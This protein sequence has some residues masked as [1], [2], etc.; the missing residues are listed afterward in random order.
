[1]GVTRNKHEEGRK[2]LGPAT[3]PRAGG[4]GCR[5]DTGRGRRDPG[6]GGAKGTVAR[7]WDRGEKTGWDPVDEEHAQEQRAAGVRN[8]ERAKCMPSAGAKK[9]K[10]VP[11]SKDG[12]KVR[13]EAKCAQRTGLYSVGT[14]P[15]TITTWVSRPAPPRPPMPLY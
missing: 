15:R 12:V 13:G 14:Q 8:T 5:C 2:E 11:T 1:M 9:K 6:D 4:G 7:P 3:L 10:S